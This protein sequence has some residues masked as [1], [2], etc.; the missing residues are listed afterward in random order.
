MAPVAKKPEDCRITDFLRYDAEE[1]TLRWTG[2]A[3]RGTRRAGYATRRGYRELE[4]EGRAYQE[5][6]VVWR[7]MK[8]VWPEDQIDH[9]DGNR[10]NNR[11]DNL[12]PCSNA[13]NQ[14]NISSSP[15]GKNKYVGVYPH[16]ASGGFQARIM[17][18][19]KSYKLGLFDTPEEAHEAYKT[20]K[21]KLHTFQ[22]ELRSA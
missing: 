8:G 3:G 16:K 17:K 13:E 20:A 4:F 5:H 21:R 7:M 1:G 2:G 18:N 22:P 6:R 14:Q 19:R 11:I 10:G 12:I 9:R 15:K